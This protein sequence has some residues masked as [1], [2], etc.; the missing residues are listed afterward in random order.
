MSGDYHRR[1]DSGAWF[2]VPA[3]IDLK[4]LIQEAY[5]P[6]ETGELLKNMKVI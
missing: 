4:S 5:S 3:C 6:K 1:F 2:L